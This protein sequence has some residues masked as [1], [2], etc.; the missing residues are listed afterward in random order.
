MT[1]TFKIRLDTNLALMKIKNYLFIF[2]LLPLL[3]PAEVSL[4]RFREISHGLYRS[5]RPNKEALQWLKN[6]HNLR[7]IINLENSS[8]NIRR[9]RGWAEDLDIQFY[10]LPMNASQT[11]RDETVDEALRLMAD[12][13]LHPLLVHCKRGRDRTGL[14]VGLFRVE[15]EGV[16][17]EDAYEEMLDLGFTT[18]LYKLD[19]YFKERTGM[20]RLLFPNNNLIATD[21]LNFNLNN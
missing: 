12:E 10:S 17:A 1:T 16:A 8:S 4:P 18:S 11:P 5:G 14:I 15:H 3:S 2:F 9:E 6:E 13:S 21:A 19:N 7:T 20:Q